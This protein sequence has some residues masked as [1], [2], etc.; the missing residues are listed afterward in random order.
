MKHNKLVRDAHPA[1]ILADG[2][3]CVY[4]EA[5]PREYQTKLLQKFYEDVRGLLN[6]TQLEDKKR[7][8]AE[9][10]DSCEE[11]MTQYGVVMSEVVAIR[12]EVK[13]KF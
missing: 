13:E 6:A 8:L 4:H 11:L 12:Q 9:L 2:R 10:H 1:S 7:R 5:S 3:T